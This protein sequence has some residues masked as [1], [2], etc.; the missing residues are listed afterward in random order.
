[1]HIMEQLRANDEQIK[2]L[3]MMNDKLRTELRGLEGGLSAPVSVD[4]L[5]MDAYSSVFD[6]AHSSG[7]H[8]S[9]GHISGHN[10]VAHS[11]V[12]HGAY[13]IQGMGGYRQNHPGLQ[14]LQMQA[15]AQQHQRQMAQTRAHYDVGV[16]GYAPRA[17]QGGNFN[18]RQAPM[19]NFQSQSSGASA[20]ASASASGATSASTLRY[21]HTP[22][23]SR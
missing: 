1:M 20:S 6:S 11:N 2:M 9:S 14:A 5:G 8:G 21:F 15:H 17:G 18:H 10:S 4:N 16:S 13:P 7:G 19:Q 23:G 22:T 3:M 12:A